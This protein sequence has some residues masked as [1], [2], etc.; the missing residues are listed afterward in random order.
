M[1]ELPTSQLELMRM[2]VEALFTHNENLRIESINQPDNGIA[3][4][5]F[6]GRTI[7][8]NL[9][10]FRTDLP[11]DLAI[12]LKKHCNGESEMIDISRMPEDQNEYIRLLEGHKPIKQIL[13]GPA[14]W[15]STDVVPSAQPVE[16]SE[17]NADLLRGGFEDWLA[18]VPHRRPFMAMVEDG[19]AVSVCA[20]A[21]DYRRRAR[22][23]RRDVA[24][25]S[26]K[27]LRDDSRCSL[28][29]CSKEDF[30]NSPI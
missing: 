25:I 22:G 13:S 12:E 9:W 26:P 21:T 16:I 6:F 4:R 27:R 11:D 3:P 28:G 14:Y 23:R 18:D 1:I 7:A 2:H 8:G 20:S 17:T 15:F 24:N 10:R 29:K 30:R 19:Q 5:F